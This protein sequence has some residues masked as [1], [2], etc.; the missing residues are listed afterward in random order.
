MIPGAFFYIF[1]QNK[2]IHA[3]NS[4][5]T[6]KSLYIYLAITQAVF[7]L[8]RIHPRLTSL[9]GPAHRE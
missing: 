8:A 3:E 2:N 7:L 1:L 6:G 4:K 5:P 9:F